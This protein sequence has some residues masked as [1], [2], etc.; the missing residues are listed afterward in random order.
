M[1]RGA[2]WQGDAA[3]RPRCSPTR[4]EMSQVCADTSRPIT[5]AWM[6]AGALFCLPYKSRNSSCAMVKWQHQVEVCSMVSLGNMEIVRLLSQLTRRARWQMHTA[7][8]RVYVWKI[9]WREMCCFELLRCRIL[10]TLHRTTMALLVVRSLVCLQT[11]SAMPR[12]WLWPRYAQDFW[13]NLQNRSIFS[14]G[15]PSENSESSQASY[16]F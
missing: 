4:H 9:N 11:S 14:V 16:A 5:V 8:P 3:G 1:Y 15:N 6:K 2:V 10:L 7:K 12:T 13:W